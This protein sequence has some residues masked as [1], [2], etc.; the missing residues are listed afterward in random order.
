ML[1]DLYLT[2]D[3]K[4]VRQAIVEVNTLALSDI[5]KLLKIKV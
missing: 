1:H 4:H 2:L 3:G 5:P